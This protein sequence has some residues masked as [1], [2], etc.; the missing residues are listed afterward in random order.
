[1]KKNFEDLIDGPP[2]IEVNKSLFTKTINV[3]MASQEL[4]HPQI[5][6]YQIGGGDYYSSHKFQIL[7]WGDIDRFIASACGEKKKSFYHMDALNEYD[8]CESPM[9]VDDNDFSADHN[10]SS[11]LSTSKHAKNKSNELID[12]EEVSS[13]IDTDDE[14]TDELARENS[15]DVIISI[16]DKVIFTS[17]DI[18]DYCFCYKQ[19]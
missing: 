15:A 1:M 12:E 17:N 10:I 19:F 18:L 9:N 6:S 7:H 14:Q 16:K 3:M 13:D 8:Q 11:A 4:S 5:M 2:I